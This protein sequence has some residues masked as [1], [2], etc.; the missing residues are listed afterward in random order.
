MSPVDM[1]IIPT[2][3]NPI[4][5]T[6]TKLG[7]APWKIQLSNPTSMVLVPAMDTTAPAIPLSTPINKKISAHAAKI[8]PIKTII[9]AEISIWNSKRPTQ[10]TKI[11]AIP[12]MNSAIKLAMMNTRD[13]NLSVQYLDRIILIPSHD[14]AM[15]DPM[16]IVKVTPPPDWHNEIMSTPPRFMKTPKVW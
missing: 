16:T 14:E 1:T 10:D 15:T 11:Q 6:C 8:P 9:W 3:V 2:V 7:V 13:S 12:K 4:A 5:S